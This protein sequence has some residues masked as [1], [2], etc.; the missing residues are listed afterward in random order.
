[1]SIDLA[2]IRSIIFC[3][4]RY[5]PS[6]KTSFNVMTRDEVRGFD[7]RAINILGIPGAV[8]MENAGKNCAEMILGR[9]KE[10]ADAEVCIFCGTGNNGGDGYVIARHLVN[11]GVTARIVIC[12]DSEKVKGDARINL[13]IARNMNISGTC[14]DPDAADLA[15]RLQ[16]M[17]GQSDIIV[18]AIF[19]TGLKGKLT[20]QYIEII[21]GINSLSKEIIAV[22]IPSGLDCDTGEPLPTAIKA[23][24]TVTFV[25]V[26]KGFTNEQS[27]AYT[28]DVYIASI[29][30]EP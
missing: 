14:L 12:G 20:S 17:A 24:A 25:A 13:D 4:K 1:M 3:M 9:L 22:D 16:D 5:D 2:G 6:E 23:A 29:G 21:E 15:G 11:A 26:K 7:A 10:P 27:I 30:I 8:L 19:G 28:G 18:D